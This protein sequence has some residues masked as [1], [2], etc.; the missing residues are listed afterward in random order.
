MSLAGEDSL[1]VYTHD[2]VLYHFIVNASP[3]KAHLVQVGQITFHGIVRA[4]ARVRSVSWVLPEQQLRMYAQ[5]YVGNIADK[6]TEDG[7]PS[8]DVAVASVFFL[9]DGKLVLLQP[10]TTEG[11]ELK[12]DMRVVAQN[13]EYYMLMRDHPQQFLADERDP[14]ISDDD[15]MNGL[16]QGNSLRDSLWVFDGNQMMVWTDVQDILRTAQADVDGG[17][18]PEPVPIPVD[19]YPLSTLLAK[20]TI[21]GIEPDLVQRR[22]INFAYFKFALR[23]CPLYSSLYLNFQSF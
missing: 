6:S 9:V 15:N 8:Q 3:D 14:T 5:F 7:D 21:L 2:N 20:G 16:L 12:Y 4:P 23:V 17:H 10:S 18:M 13:V 11:G 1:L 19:F 22:D